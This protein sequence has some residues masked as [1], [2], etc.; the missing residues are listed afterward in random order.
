MLRGARTMDL[1]RLTRRMSSAQPSWLSVGRAC[2]ELLN[3]L[4]WRELIAN[5]HTHAR[6]LHT[7]GRSSGE[8][9]S[10]TKASSEAAPGGQ[11]E[12]REGSF[13]E[14]GLVT[15][16]R[17]ADLDPS[18]PAAA[19]HVIM[20]RFLGALDPRE[21]VACKQKQATRFAASL[22]RRGADL[23]EYA[24]LLH[25]SPSSSSVDGSP[26]LKAWGIALQC[27]RQR[28][29]LEGIWA[30]VDRMRG[31][32]AGAVDIAA[33]NTVLAAYAEAGK[34]PAAMALLDLL[35]GAPRD[36]PS[37]PLQERVAAQPEMQQSLEQVFRRG[38]QC[39]P[40]HLRADTLSVNTL[41]AALAKRGMSRDALALFRRAFQINPLTGL[42]IRE[43]IDAHSRATSPALSLDPA[44]RETREWAEERSA[45]AATQAA[46][47]ARA[48][49]ASEAE[50]A[51]AMAM[52]HRPALAPNATSWVELIKA[53]SLA[54][55]ETSAH[56]VFR[57]M[58]RQGGHTQPIAWAMLAR[59]YAYSG[60]PDMAH[61]QLVAA[62]RESALTMQ[63]MWEEV[64][65]GYSSNEV[66][67]GVEL[68]L[69]EFFRLVRRNARR[70]TSALQRR[71][72]RELQRAVRAGDELTGLDAK[73]G[74]EAG[75]GGDGDGDEDG[76]SDEV[77]FDPARPGMA[78]NLAASL[79]L[80]A[81]G[82]VALSPGMW[83]ALQRACV[84]C[85]RPQIALRVFMSWAAA[86]IPTGVGMPACYTEQVPASARAQNLMA[87]LSLNPTAFTLHMPDAVWRD[88]RELSN[89]PHARTGKTLRLFS[90]PENVLASLS[91]PAE[92]HKRPSFLPP[93]PPP[94]L[95]ASDA[96]A[97]RVPRSKWLLGLTDK[98][99]HPDKE[100]WEMLIAAAARDGDVATTER[101]VRLFQETRAHA[102]E[103]AAA[104]LAANG[105]VDM[106]PQAALASP[107]ADPRELSDAIL[108]SLVEAPAV[109]GDAKGALQLLRDL[110]LA[111][112]GWR[113][114]GKAWGFVLFSAAQLGH[115]ELLERAL[116]EMQRT[117]PG[118]LTS[119]HARA[120]IRSLLERGRIA[121][122]IKLLD[123]SR[124][125]GLRV[126]AKFEREVSQRLAE[127]TG[128]AA[129]SPLPPTAR[130]VG[131]LQWATQAELDEFFEEPHG[132]S[133]WA[134]TEEVVGEE[135]PDDVGE[136]DGDG[137]AAARER[138]P[139]RPE[140]RGRSPRFSQDRSDRAGSRSS[141][142]S[143]RRR[144]EA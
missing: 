8:R 45:K 14:M 33:A 54:R 128:A 65:D 95:A 90:L 15:S 22:A 34:I 140:Q 19:A 30:T 92:Y 105:G 79:P 18:A 75:G 53:F 26:S 130:K 27:D 121:A 96:E 9:A 24:E 56:A 91:S 120:L 97:S 135:Q 88:L 127:R 113:A 50:I 83:R 98:L 57:A 21:R 119:V 29:D 61:Q 3:S 87:T 35:L 17:R 107:K 12:G 144:R 63:V 11:A 73:Q 103:R 137:D 68:V 106:L 76:D 49:G 51:Q 47:A 71:E 42:P 70:R 13:F 125:S 5:A 108:T 1:R 4:H 62:L 138:R 94:L 86:G 59:A 142:H 60:K 123:S 2:A 44:L 16:L 10:V 67:N 122:A 20:A 111:N 114:S 112:P 89:R 39:F 136:G 132:S 58:R 110:Q 78:I 118:T 134:P 93:S 102:M 74:D 99:M 69:A 115:V 31:S 101:L 80:V 52:K 41:M 131:Q 133:R 23:G 7:G 81:D 43:A 100:A 104:L 66:F 40:E 55:S 84:R 64:V 77:F 129:S 116:A 32:A 143:S 141:S 36:A 124:A 72:A 117:A 126:G 28:R 25:V 82:L 46:A 85:L 6:T 139:R 48:Q 38:V 37:P 109:A